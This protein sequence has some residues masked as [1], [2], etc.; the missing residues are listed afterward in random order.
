MTLRNEGFSMYSLSDLINLKLENVAG[1]KSKYTYFFHYIQNVL[2]TNIDGVEEICL[3]MNHFSFDAQLL[4]IF[5]LQQMEDKKIQELTTDLVTKLELI[6]VE[7][8]IPRKEW[9]NLIGNIE[10]KFGNTLKIYKTLLLICAFVYK[11]T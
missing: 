2:L 10:K 6:K 7:V 1:N 11:T 4:I 9:L 8:F 5:Q 3:L